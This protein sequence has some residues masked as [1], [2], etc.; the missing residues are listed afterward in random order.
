VRN[1][2]KVR[3]VFYLTKNKNDY[4]SVKNSFCMIFA[5]FKNMGRPRKDT[6]DIHNLILKL[7]QTGMTNTAIAHVTGLAERTIY[8]YLSDTNLGETVKAVRHAASEIDAETKAAI[9][10]S[11]IRAMKRLLRPRKIKETETRM[12]ACGQVYMTIEKEKQLEPH[13]RV[14][15]FALKNLAPKTWNAAENAANIANTDDN[16]DTDIRIVIDDNSQ[17]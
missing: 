10:K 13:A 15:E 11:A 2:P 14:V 4:I 1:A 6:V 16:T 3:R 7:A 17:Q 5:D 9:N 8:N 12:N